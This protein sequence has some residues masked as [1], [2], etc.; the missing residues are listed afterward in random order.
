MISH[1][2]IVLSA[3]LDEI[4]ESHRIDGRLPSLDEIFVARIG[5]A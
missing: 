1:G 3:P 4:K 5:K 2:E